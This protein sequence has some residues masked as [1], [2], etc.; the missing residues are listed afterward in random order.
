MH[1]ELDSQIERMREIGQKDIDRYIK[2][3]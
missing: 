3:I 2:D 1:Y